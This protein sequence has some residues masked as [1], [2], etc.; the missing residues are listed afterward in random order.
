MKTQIKHIPFRVETLSVCT[1]PPH[2]L[3]VE[4]YGN[5]N[6]GLPI[7]CVHGG[8]GGESRCQS[9]LSLGVFDL[10]QH[11]V[12]FF[13][14]RGCGQSTPFAE[15]EKN[16]PMN[17]IQDMERIRKHLKWKRMVLFGGSYGTSL[18]L[19]YTIRYPHRVLRYILRGVY[20]MG[21]VISET[22]QRLHP[23]LWK[24][25][26]RCTNQTTLKEIAK[27]VSHKIRTNHKTK[28]QCA[29]N[30]CALEES[31]LPSSCKKHT[32]FKQQH[33]TALMEAHHEANGFFLPATY[34]LLKECRKM[35]GVSGL[36]VHGDAD[37]ICPVANALALYNVLDHS[38]VRLVVVKYGGHSAQQR[39]MRRA[40]RKEVSV[41]LA[42]S[43]R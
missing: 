34:N 39:L 43:L 3:H 36:I 38:E 4:H 11:H 8:P 20:L 29:R 41:F 7:L 23:V 16:T 22:L 28:K 17:T 24:R 9:V 2:C 27:T 21:D 37:I 5:P 42:P 19:M 1:R 10:T 15:C 33:C 12:V 14:Q 32:T 13:D 35:R 40:L 6:N 31:A 26:Q 25:L 18:I 30:W